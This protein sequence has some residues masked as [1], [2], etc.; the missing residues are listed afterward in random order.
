MKH[1]GEIFRKIREE[2]GFTLEQ[3]AKGVC[4]HQTVAN[5][6]EK[7]S[8]LGYRS[9]YGILKN[10]GVS[11]EEFWYEMN[12]YKLDTFDS[13]IQKANILYDANDIIALKGLLKN[14]E[15]RKQ[16]L[17]Y[18]HDLTCLMI[19]SMIGRMDSTVVLND[20]EKNKIVD[21]LGMTEHWGFYELT[22]FSTTIESFSNATLKKL[23]KYFI[24]RSEFYSE[25]PKNKNMIA[26]TLLNLMGRLTYYDEYTFASDLSKRIQG[27]LEEKDIFHRTIFLYNTGVL[28]VS[29]DNMAGLKKMQ[30][31]IYVFELVESKQLAKTYQ[32][33]YDHIKDEL[34]K[35]GKI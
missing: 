25:I 1:A 28:E 8:N 32:V 24:S 4:R 6:E 29:M 27:L 3:V 33:N 18:R 14:E 15:A 26:L 13:L 20:A 31:A 9:F 7:A 17:E 23:S 34:T 10:V 30:D 12:R 2:R 11:L 16:N 21:Y 5:F 35:K 19:K 22:L